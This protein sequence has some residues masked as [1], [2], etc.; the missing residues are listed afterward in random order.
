MIRRV[1]EVQQREEM[2]L[3]NEQKDA[4]ERHKN[5]QELMGLLK[6]KAN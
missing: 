1:I 3:N 2:E 4:L 5:F 6:K